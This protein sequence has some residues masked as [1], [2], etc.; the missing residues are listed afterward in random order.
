[1]SLVAARMTSL[2]TEMVVLAV[3]SR[4]HVKGVLTWAIAVM[5]ACDCERSRL[6]MGLLEMLVIWEPLLGGGR[7][8]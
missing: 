1:M 3:E 7:F 8:C 5:H 6:E 4:D 2:K